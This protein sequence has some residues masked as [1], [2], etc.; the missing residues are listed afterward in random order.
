ML[1]SHFRIGGNKNVEEVKEKGTLVQFNNFG[2]IFLRRPE[3]KI[4]KFAFVIS[5]KVSKLANRR[6]R[7]KRALSEAVRQRINAIPPGFDFVFLAKKE[8]EKKT[9]DE[10]MRE[11][12]A[13]FENKS[14]LSKD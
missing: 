12:F 1:A 14:W 10:I 5:T 8:V 13:A 2:L 6:N 9:T 11:V 4:P 3:Q 7:I